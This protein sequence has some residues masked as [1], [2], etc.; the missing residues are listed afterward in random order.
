MFL[1]L[2]LILLIPTVWYGV[3]VFT[4]PKTASKI[5]AMIW[6]SWFSENFRGTKVNFDSVI[7][8]IPSL[9]E[10][11]SWAL[12]IKDTVVDGVATTKDTIDSVRGWAQKIEETY[13]DARDVVEGI[14]GKVT[15]IKNTLDDVQSLGQNISNVVNTDLVESIDENK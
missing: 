10:F 5:D 12:D 15:E 13:N 9:N 7:T 1:K 6:I 3:T 14:N 4:A 2:I 8:D 11:K